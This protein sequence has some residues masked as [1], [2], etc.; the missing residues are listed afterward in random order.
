ME[1]NFLAHVLVDLKMRNK[2]IFN[3]GDLY[4][5]VDF[6]KK[7]ISCMVQALHREHIGLLT[8]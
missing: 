4:V 5:D 6:L 3:K 2:K 7:Q 1:C 8:K